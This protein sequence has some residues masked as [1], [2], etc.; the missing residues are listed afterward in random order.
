MFNLPTEVQI[1]CLDGNARH[2]ELAIIEALGGG[3]NGAL[4]QAKFIVPSA[5]Y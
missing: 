5:L 2:M 4:Q 3:S 1:I